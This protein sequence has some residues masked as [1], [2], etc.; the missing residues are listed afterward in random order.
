MILVTSKCQNKATCGSAQFY[1]HLCKFL[2]AAVLWLVCHVY[3]M[4][5]VVVVDSE[6]GMLSLLKSRHSLPGKCHRTGLSSYHCSTRIGS[7]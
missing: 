3:V 1:H 2:I 6:F 5:S 4:V 7:T